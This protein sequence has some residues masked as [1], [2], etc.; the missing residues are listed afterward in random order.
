[1]RKHDKSAN[2]L[3]GDTSLT[4]HSQHARQVLENLLRSSPMVRSDPEVAA[5]ITKLQAAMQKHQ[6]ESGDTRPRRKPFL[7]AHQGDFKPMPPLEGVLDVLRAARAADALFFLIWSPFFAPEKLIGMCEQ[8]YSQP[9]ACSLALRTLVYGCLHYVFVEHLSG[10][11][12]PYDSPLWAHVGIFASNFELCLGQHRAFSASNFETVLALVFGAGHAIQTDDF[13]LAWACNTLAARLCQ[14][15]GWHR[16]SPHGAEKTRSQVILFWIIYYMDKC[17]S[18]RFGRASAIQDFDVT[19]DLPRDSEDPTLQAWNLWFR[20][21]VEIGTLHGLVYEKL[22]SPGSFSQ[23]PQQ[24]DATAQDIAAK[25]TAAALENSSIPSLTVYRRQYMSYLVKS[26]EVVLGCLLTLTYRAVLPT[27]SDP[28]F[29]INDACLDAARS[30]IRGHLEVVAS[31][32]GGQEGSASDYVSWTM[33]NC[34]FTPFIVLF[35][36]IVISLDT[37]DL[38][39]LRS[40][41]DSLDLLVLRS[42]ES[43][44]RFRQLCNAFCVLAEHYVRASTRGFDVEMAQDGTNNA[45]SWP[46]SKGDTSQ[47]P[48]PSACDTPKSVHAASNGFDTTQAFDPNLTILPSELFDDWLAGSQQMN[49]LWDWSSADTMVDTSFS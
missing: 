37:D 18:L 7:D 3:L 15:L 31:S 25:L 42:P 16:S 14:N 49:F 8:V 47:H 9:Q 28:S 29:S 44:S 43:M 40:F 17:L 4:A 46:T 27:Q 36:H 39:L 35:S 1:M 13:A 33:L 11:K 20:V 6:A 2:P 10:T 23:S 21:L 30:T 38:Q 12:T 19:V 26:N 5:S 22:Y 34:P 45:V 32:Q 24:R 41:V 48:L